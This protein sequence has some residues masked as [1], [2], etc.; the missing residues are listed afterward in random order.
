MEEF[1]N[2]VFTSAMLGFPAWYLGRFVDRTVD[3]RGMLARIGVNTLVL[4]IVMILLPWEVTMNF[5]DTVPGAMA[6]AIF[7]NSQ[8]W[9]STK[10]I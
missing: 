8:R 4:W 6:C 5:Q 3:K 10:L 2:F 1:Y 7:F 9:D